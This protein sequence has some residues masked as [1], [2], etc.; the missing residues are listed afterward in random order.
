[1]SGWIKLHRK[2]TTWE[3]WDDHNTTRLFVFIITQAN[4]K[5]K[6]WQ[7]NTIKRG[8]FITSYPK[9]ASMTGL[10]IKQIRTSIKHLKKTGEVAVKSTTQFTKVIVENY[11]LYQIDGQTDGLPKEGQRADE[12]QTKGRRRAT[13]KNVKKVKNDKNEKKIDISFEIFWNLYNYKVGDKNKVRKK[14]ES[15]TDLDRGMVME[16][17][18]HY[19]QSTPDKQFRKHPATYLNNQGWFDEIVNKNNGVDKFKLSTVGF[20][21]AYC[22]KCGVSAEY[23]KEELSGESRCCQG[24]LLS[25]RPIAVR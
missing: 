25:E 14:W 9:M 6:K 24:S 20:P 22:D 1:M 7:G 17:L 19:I 23:R 11:S 12:G 13:T 10:S 2:I 4:H 16:H 18:P 8:E 3:W 21:M 15:L 5:Q